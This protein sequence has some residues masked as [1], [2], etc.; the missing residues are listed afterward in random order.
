MFVA[1]T[2]TSESWTRFQAALGE[3]EAGVIYRSTKQQR[4]VSI[5]TYKRAIMSLDRSTEVN[6]GSSH[7]YAQ[8]ADIH[9]RIATLLTENGRSEAAATQYAGSRISAKEGLVRGP[10]DPYAW[11]VLAYSEQ[12]FDG[13]LSAEALSALNMSFATG[14]IEGGLLIPRISMCFR[15]WDRLPDTLK[16]ATRGQIELA[17]K[18]NNLR[19]RLAEYVVS[20]A[21]GSQ[22]DFLKLV[23]EESAGVPDSLR[24]FQYWLRVLRRDLDTRRSARSGTRKRLSDTDAKQ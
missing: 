14:A 4:S 24:T 23:A 18:N 19:R 2:L 17:M 10:S 11:F 9:L 22:E 6:P 7:Y 12:A 8:A 13:G 20:L 1:L 15:Y 3:M 5:A 16:E 21:P